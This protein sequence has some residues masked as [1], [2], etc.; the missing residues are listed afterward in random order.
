[1]ED[2]EKQV[3]EDIL[4]RQQL[5]IKKYGTT[6]ADNKL[7]LSQWYQHLYEELLD[8]CVYARRALEEIKEREMRFVFTC[9]GCGQTTWFYTND[10][11]EWENR[12]EFIRCD[13]CLGDE[14]NDHN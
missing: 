8:S 5:G 6:V 7:P 12:E 2:I 13:Q 4:V 14:I 9:E 3:C 1:M 11:S 10:L